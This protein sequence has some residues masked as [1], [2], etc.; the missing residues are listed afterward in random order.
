[1]PKIP[2]EHIA[3]M[4]QQ[5]AKAKANLGLHIADF[6]EKLTQGDA[7]ETVVLGCAQELLRGRPNTHLAFMFATAL[8]ALTQA[9]G[10][11]FSRPRLD[12]PQ[13]D[14]A[15]GSPLRSADGHGGHASLEFEINGARFVLAAFNRRNH[16]W[17]ISPINQQAFDT[18]LLAISCEVLHD[19][20]IVKKVPRRFGDVVPMPWPDRR[21]DR[22]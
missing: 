18:G 7:P 20:E 19:A 5:Y 4:D 9:D 2:P 3:E 14:P 6:R 16:V 21:G 13:E 17:H 15:G 12:W 1:M 11:A 10:N 8:M 22:E